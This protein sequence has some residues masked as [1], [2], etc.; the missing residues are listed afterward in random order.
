MQETEASEIELGE[1][2]GPVLQALVSHMYGK[3]SDIE[4]H[5]VLPLFMAADAHQVCLLNWIV[6]IVFIAPVSAEAGWV[7][8]AGDCEKGSWP[9]VYIYLLGDLLT[10]PYIR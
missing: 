1:M 4:D 10:L 7:S 2:E 3:L 9:A 5:L 8:C 6:S